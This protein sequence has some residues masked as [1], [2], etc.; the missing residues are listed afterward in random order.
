MALSLRDFVKAVLASELL[1]PGLVHLAERGA[2]ADEFKSAPT[3]PAELR[4]LLMWRNGLDLEVVRL[5]GVGPA[6]PRVEPAQVAGSDAVA[7]ASDPAG[8]LY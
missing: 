3:L 6:I 7:F 1:E 8:F 2:T 4:E 5:H